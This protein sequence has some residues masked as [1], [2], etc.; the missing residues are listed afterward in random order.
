[1]PHS[2][3]ITVPTFVHHVRKPS[4]Q[5]L[6]VQTELANDFTPA[7]SE[8]REFSQRSSMDSSR[9]QD[10]HLQPSP[11]HPRR[12]SLAF[13][14][15]LDDV[16]AFSPPL[17]ASSPALGPVH[18][19]TPLPSPIFRSNSPELWRRL[20]G[21]R[22]GS[23]GS[24]IGRGNDSMEGSPMLAA[25]QMSPPGHKRNKKS[26]PSLG[27]PALAA[28]REQDQTRSK[29][30]SI[31]EFVPDP[32]SNIRPR[33]V[34]QP[35]SE[36]EKAEQSQTSLQ[37]PG[38]HREDFLAGQKR[39]HV[40][41]VDPAKTIPSPPPSNKSTID[42]DEAEDVHPGT[43]D[44][45]K[46]IRIH[47]R[48]HELQKWR[49][50]R[51]L[52]QGAFSQVFLCARDDLVVKSDPQIEKHLEP[53]QLVAIK[54]V[55]HDKSLPTDE[56]ARMET[57]IGREIEI[58]E[59]LSHPCLPQ[60][61][62]FDD[63]QQR[64]VLVLD[65]CPGGDMFEL[66]SQQRELLTPPLIQRIFAELIEAVGYLHK[67]WICHRDIKLE[68]V[69]FDVP[70]ADLPRIGDPLNYPRALITLTDLGL[71]KRIPKPPESPFLTHNC[72]S[73]DYAAPEL[74]LQQPYDG[75]LVDMWALGVTLYALMEGR[76]PF[77]P[78]PG[79]R[80]QA[81]VNHRIARCDWLWVEHG[82]ENGDWVEGKF[83]DL[84]G[85]REVVEGTL[86]KMNR[87]RWTQEKAAAHPW[88]VGQTG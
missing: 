84:E 14:R 56:E 57:S 50:L 48:G 54:V 18:D 29:A 83:S 69:L 17:S 58:L 2:P 82:D 35:G 77:D 25:L 27:S 11:T 51:M 75:R 71:A 19:V 49:P 88:S 39:K 4:S 8:R 63:S 13:R 31:S 47:P 72:G 81:N 12:P 42:S 73:V 5:G 59:N 30:R 67:N 33:I 37:S 66:A 36:A 15:S 9:G 76:L 20:V 87:G 53:S 24:S 85:A 65:Y 80:R 68:N 43:H 60:L 62:T 41:P 74:L 64:A 23:S 40:T 46:V 45:R 52:G 44:I 86:K 10:I 3:N 28:T 1:M 26:Y 38:L 7:R 79:R 55:T 22:R 16:N 78:L 6:S 21:R 34:T 61:L 32:L 70:I